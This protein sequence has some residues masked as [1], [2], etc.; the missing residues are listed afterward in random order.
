MKILLGTMPPSD[1]WVSAELPKDVLK[2]L[3]DSLLSSSVLVEDENFIATMREISHRYPSLSTLIVESIRTIPRSERVRELDIDCVFSSPETITSIA[4]NPAYLSA[5]DRHTSIAS[6]K[7]TRDSFYERTFGH[8]LRSSK[9]F[10][11]YD[12][13]GLENLVKPYS[14]ISWLVRE[15]LSRLPLQ[16]ELHALTSVYDAATLEAVSVNQVES[17]LRGTKNVHSDF[18]VSL[19]LYEKIRKGS[20]DRFARIV[21]DRNSVSCELSKGAEIFR[22][23]TLSEAYKIHALTLNEFEAKAGSWPKDG[24]VFRKVLNL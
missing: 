14:G 5:R 3:W 2:T 19:I 17:L 9:R 7:E 20:H 11:V 21:F 4:S 15:R 6:P 1:S 23:A 10:V 16:L 24:V 12:P 8:L 22:D 13:Y 18:S